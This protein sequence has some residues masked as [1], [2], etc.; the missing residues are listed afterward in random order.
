MIGFTTPSARN[1]FDMDLNVRTKKSGAYP[2]V[3]DFNTSVIQHFY[4]I[5]ITTTWNAFRA[6][7]VSRRTVNTFKNRLDKQRVKNPIDWYSDRRCRAS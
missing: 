5:K 7:V 2:I 4:L 1:F 3:K 6:E